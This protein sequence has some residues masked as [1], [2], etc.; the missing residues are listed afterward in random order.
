MKRHQTVSILVPIYNVENYIVRCARSLF[1]QSYDRCRF[2]FVD[3]YST[4]DSLKRL[5]RIIE[6][7]Y[8]H[9][10]DRIIIIRHVRNRGVAATRN[11]AMECVDSDFILFVDSDDW[12][13]SNMVAKLIREQR[14][15][16]AD[17]V[18]S[19]FMEVKNSKS[20]LVSTHW[21]G[22]REGSLQVV[23]AQ[24]FA[25][26]N[27]VW[28]ILVRNSLIHNNGIRFNCD[29]RYGEDALFLVQLLYYSRE[30]GHVDRPLYNY[31]ADS[32]GSYTNNQSRTSMR[33]YIRSQRLIYQFIVDRDA[34]LRYGTALVLGRM[35]LRRWLIRRNS[36]RNPL[37][38]LYRLWCYVVNRVWMLTLLFY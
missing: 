7:E 34:V 32:A 19:D 38:M 8:S 31:R 21:I 16:D 4:D 36:P 35:N 14:K 29:V 30:V 28:S 11:T 18:S 9:L 13:E 26:P 24:S 17:I 37:G 27:R 22:G 33:N 23:L 6:D 25:L 1:E 3:D 5:E 20:K 12:C 15:T 10:R 2:I